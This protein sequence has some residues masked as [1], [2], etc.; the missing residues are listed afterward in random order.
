MIIGPEKL[1]LLIKKGREPDEPDP[2]VIVPTP[3]IT[4]MEKDGSGS[5][6]LR[7]GTWFVNLRQARKA[8]LDIGEHD[9]K[10][11]AKSHYVRFNDKYYLHPG[12][13]ILGITLEWVRLPVNI[14]AYVIGKSSWGR[15]GLI[16]AT[17]TAVHP[18][19]IGCLTL[20]I[21]NVGEMPIVI[22]P[23]MKICQLCFHGVDRSDEVM[24]DCSQFIG[25]RKP[26]IGAVKVD[27]FAKM[28]SG[29]E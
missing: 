25:Y 27:T 15:R 28:L 3:D 22:R 17:A 19:F 8:E 6:D 16:I 1:A 21:S 18:G 23:G 14:F 10:K 24:V 5:I 12:N 11:V 2:L 7:L 4:E 20:E 29:I 9:H 13:F 26:E